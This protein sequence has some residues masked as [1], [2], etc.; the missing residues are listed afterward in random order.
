MKG[1]II[2]ILWIS[3]ASLLGQSKLPSLPEGFNIEWHSR[4]WVAPLDIDFDHEGKMYVT[5]KNGSVWIVKDGKKNAQPLIDISDEVANFGDNGLLSFALDRDFDLNGR[6]YLYYIVD[7]YHWRYSHQPD[8]DPSANEYWNATIARVTR[9]SADPSDDLESIIPGSRHVLIGKTQQDGIPSLY[10]SHM[11]G[12]LEIGDDGSL[13]ISTGDGSTW[14][15][16]YGGNGP[17]YYEE[18]VEQALLDEIITPDQELGSFRAQYIDNY[19]GKILRVDPDTGLG[20]PGNPYFNEVYPDDVRSK[21]FALGLRNGYRMKVRRGSGSSSID[22]GLPGTMY[23]MD[24]GNENW[25]ELNVVTIPGQNFGWPLYE[26]IEPMPIFQAMSTRHPMHRSADE[27]CNAHKGYLFRDLIQQPRTI[28]PFNTFPDPC[29]EEIEIDPGITFIHSLP[30]LAL[31]HWSVYGSFYTPT[32]DSLGL[33]F[34]LQIDAP[35][36]PIYGVSQGWQGIC[37]IVGG[38]Y[39]GTT[40]PEWYQDK[41]F[42]G[43]YDRGWIKVIETDLNDQILGVTD[44]FTDTIK[45]T[46]IEL[47]P[48]DGALYFIDFPRGIKKITYGQ[49][50]KPVAIIKSDRHYGQSPLTI[51]LDAS[52]SYDPND[53]EVS[54]EWDF[55]N[56]DISNLATPQ[57]T[58]DDISTAPQSLWIRLTVYD[59]E[60]LSDTD[61]LLISLNNTPPNVS[62]LNIEDGDTYAVD[63]LTFLKMEANISD[64]E[65]LLSELSYRWQLFLGHN[66]HEHPEPIVDDPSPEIRILPTS[67]GAEQFYY[68]IELNVMDPAGLSGIDSKRLVPDC[69]GVFVD[70]LVLSADQINDGIE[71]KWTTGFEKGLS[72]I[73]IEGSEGDAAD[74]DLIG[75]IK[76]TNQGNMRWQYSYKDLTV[77][78]GTK[79]YRLRFVSDRGQEVYSQTIETLFIHP[80]TIEIHPNPVFDYLNVQFGQIEGTG[81]IKILD[82]NGRLVLEEKFNALGGLQRRVDLRELTPAIYFYQLSNG[83]LIKTGRI[84]RYNR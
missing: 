8:Y 29:G 74:F 1:W 33:P 24:V 79:K 5:E 10:T 3:V 82:V 81:S 63:G 38:F 70:L 65:H 22:D 56:G 69:D 48:H 61:S 55:G 67:C 16:L 42:I 37:G 71:L 7:R 15:Q 46:H 11:G 21:V 58:F 35:E 60:G 57:V 76:G 19:N 13:L 20:L 66:T 40:F 32:Y 45:I 59:Q 54:Y 49:N 4:D 23:V 39:G 41:L 6:F 34:R 64:E 26:G 9:Y 77:K 52:D 31:G 27:D 36:S 28:F 2:I 53:S 14:K 83:T 72:T 51:Q 50:V 75:E 47:N 73:Y 12:T 44:F 62:I 78:D 25:E 80:E 17:P 18:Y 84:R 30:H 68:R 43:D